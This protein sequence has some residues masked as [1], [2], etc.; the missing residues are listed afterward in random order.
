VFITVPRKHDRPYFGL[1]SMIETSAG[2]WF[3]SWS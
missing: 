1:H 2:L 3:H